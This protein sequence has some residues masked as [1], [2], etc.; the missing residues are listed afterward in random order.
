[1][2]Q[3]APPFEPRRFRTTAPYYARYRLGYPPELV[4]RVCMMVGLARGDAVMDLG[5]GPGLLALPFA[6]A[7]MRVMAIDPEPEMLGAG[8]QAAAD[9][10]VEVDFRQGSSYDLPVG[11]GPFKLV[12]MGRSFHWLD[13]APTLGA[14]DRLIVSGGAIALFEDDHPPT[15]ENAWRRVLA[16]VGR[17]Y[18]SDLAAHRAAKQQSDYRTHA[19]FLFESAF[20]HIERVGIIIRRTITAGEIV[21]RA[22]S[23]SVLSQ[24]ALGTRAP[25]FKTE[26]RSELAKLS[27]DGRFTEIVEIGALVARRG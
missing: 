21:G 12:A 1:M 15:V 2:S 8:R 10:M 9:A 22:H 11:I 3:A 19:S 4:A 14:L 5:C 23:L 13:R 26:L 17:R 20:S 18:G 6:Q 24:E 7:G 27:A 25:A 16:D